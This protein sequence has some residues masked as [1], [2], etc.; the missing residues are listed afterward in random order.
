MEKLKSSDNHEPLS[1]LV[2]LVDNRNK[3]KKVNGCFQRKSIFFQLPY[4]KDLLV[5]HCLDVMDIENNVCESII[6]TLLD[7]PG[8]TKDG[9]SSRL[10]LVEMGIRHRLAPEE[11]GART[12]LP[13]ACFTLSKEE[14]QAVCQSLAEMKMT[15]GYSLN[16]RNLV[17][18]QDL[19]LIGMKSHDCHIL[20]Q[21]LLPISIQSV[22][23]KRVR[24]S[25][26][27]VCIFF[28]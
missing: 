11:K 18:R 5:R 21:Q 19:K 28:N 26:T 8:K 27:S 12:Y 15:D 3:N 1:E 6:G 23:P 9:L 2:Q 7:I 22:L 14:K 4:W 13:P 17:S 25:V 20:M 10:D 24:D 16:V